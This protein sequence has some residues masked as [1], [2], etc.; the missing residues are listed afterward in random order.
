MQIFHEQKMHHFLKSQ[1]MMRS[2]IKI[3]QNRWNQI[4]SRCL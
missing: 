1:E 3:N 2:R 4:L